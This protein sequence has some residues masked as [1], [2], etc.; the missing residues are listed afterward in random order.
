MPE[1]K[2]ERKLFVSAIST[3]F[4]PHRRGFYF[5]IARRQ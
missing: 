4:S 5:R 3:Y 1:I 2:P